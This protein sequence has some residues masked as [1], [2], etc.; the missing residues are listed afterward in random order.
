MLEVALTFP[1]KG[2]KE[3]D[4]AFYDAHFYKNKQNYVLKS[5]LESTNTEVTGNIISAFSKI[6]ITF[7]ENLSM[8]DYQLIR[9]AIFL[10]A[11]HLQA[12]MDDT[13]AFMG[14]LENG[15]K[16]YLFH[17]WKN[18]K[19]FLL[20]AKYKSMKGQKVEVK[21]KAG[22]WRGILLDYQETFVN[23]EC[24]ITYCTLLTAL[25]EKRVN[26]KFLHVEATGEFI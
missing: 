8:N 2:I 5:I 21:S 15:Q 23:S 12:D 3:I 22:A 16:A 11:H 6:T 4:N 14:Y 1:N 25:G 24:I 18:W 13:K 9:E 19:A 7:S 20:H 10:L 17:E 26:G